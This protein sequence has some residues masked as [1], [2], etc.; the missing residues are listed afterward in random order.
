MRMAQPPMGLYHFL[1]CSTSF[2]VLSPS[3]SFRLYRV[4]FRLMTVSIPFAPLLHCSILFYDPLMISQ[5]S[6]YIRPLYN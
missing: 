5:V 2:Y 3:L 6:M 4:P 1:V